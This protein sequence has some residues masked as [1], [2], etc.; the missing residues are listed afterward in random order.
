[1]EW[2]AKGRDLMEFAK[3]VYSSLIYSC[4]GLVHINKEIYLLERFVFTDEDEILLVG[5]VQLRL[6]LKKMLM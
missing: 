6:E 2:S 3:I 4:S 1:L 5:C